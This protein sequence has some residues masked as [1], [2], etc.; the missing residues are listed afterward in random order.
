MPLGLDGHLMAHTSERRK[1]VFMVQY[2]EHLSPIL[3]LEVVVVAMWA[4]HLVLGLPWFQSR[5]PDV[6]WQHGRLF[7]LRTPV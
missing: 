3:E 4:H 6:N 5:D 7:A 2:M 1:T